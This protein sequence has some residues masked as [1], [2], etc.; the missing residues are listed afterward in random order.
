MHDFMKS[1]S[2]IVMLRALN[3]GVFWPVAMA[4]AP[5]GGTTRN[6][7][8]TV[9]RTRLSEPDSQL[10]RDHNQ[11]T[12]AVL[13]DRAHELMHTPKQAMASHFQLL[14]P[15]IALVSATKLA[16]RASDAHVGF[17]GVQHQSAFETQGCEGG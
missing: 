5:G 14:A 6:V 13:I 3:G 15:Y 17:P 2:V 12:V 10:K 4:R 16:H 7:A 9:D 8:I 1:G 11:R